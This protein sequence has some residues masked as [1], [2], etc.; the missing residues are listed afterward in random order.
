M[1]RTPRFHNYDELLA[2]AQALLA[3]GYER[4]GNWSL[5]QAC[6]HVA[7]TMEKSLD[8]F[9]DRASWLF[10][11][12][13]RTFVLP[14]ILKH[15]QFNRRFPA[16]TYLLPPDGEDDRAGIEAMRSAA[17]R[18]K[19][20]PGELQRHPVFGK[21]TRSQWQELHLWHSEHHLSYLVPKKVAAPA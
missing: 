8:G 1:R 7:S 16:P 17:A 3:N 5:G 4:Q 21:L 19:A 15:R 11:F 20:H 18:L 9:P 10:E 13:A 12:A 14:N 6:R 2:D